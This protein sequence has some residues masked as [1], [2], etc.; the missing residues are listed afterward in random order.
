M[1]YTTAQ[2]R[3]ARAKDLY[4]FLLRHHPLAFR[5]EGHSL[6]SAG[7]PSISIREGYCG[8]VDFSTGETGNSIDFLTKHLNYT[9]N[10]AVSVLLEETEEQFPS[11]PQGMAVNDSDLQRERPLSLPVPLP[12][13]PRRLTDYLEQRGIPVW[14]T[15]ELYDK[16]LVYL[17]AGTNNL[18]FLNRKK[19]FC[20]LRGTVPGVSF[21]QCR[22]SAPDRFWSFRSGDSRPVRAMI[23]EG[24]IDAMSLFLLRQTANEEDNRTLYCGIGGVYNQKVIERI[25]SFL[26]VVIAVD[27][28]PAGAS[29][30][31]RNESE[32]FLIPV[33]KDWNE[34]LCSLHPS[35]R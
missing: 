30:R 19:D 10:E 35:E 22:K 1:K 28:D 23:C 5:R 14:L 27:N 24:A 33:G 12:G 26:P 18:V 32:P 11:G 3:T 31:S 20:E 13:K 2:I 25:R 4:V 7:N 34:D 17:E 15:D 9:F 8:F 21:H 16:G 29:C 6:R